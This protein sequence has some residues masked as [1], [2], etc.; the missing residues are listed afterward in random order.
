MLLQVISIQFHPL[1]HALHSKYLIDSWPFSSIF[2]QELFR[3]LLQS[4]RIGARDRQEFTSHNFEDQGSLIISLEWML[5]SAELIQDTS[6][7]P[8]V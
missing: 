8:N 1:L 4:L 6:Q 3:Q 7:G 5:I 2:L